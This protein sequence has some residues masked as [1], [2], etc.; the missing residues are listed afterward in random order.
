MAGPKDSRAG[1]DDVPGRVRDRHFLPGRDRGAEPQ[2]RDGVLR[3]DADVIPVGQVGLAGALDGVEP[4]VQGEEPGPVPG[5]HPQ[6]AGRA[7]AAPGD[8]QA[9][10]VADGRL[11][12]DAEQDRGRLAGPGREGAVEDQRLARELAAQAGR[13]VHG[14]AGDAVRRDGHRRPELHEVREG[15]AGFLL[16]G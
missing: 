5:E 13:G 2:D 6:P 9:D 8:V 10:R 14:Q 11:R 1:D 16:A 7:G 12:G 4:Q 15:L 3:Q